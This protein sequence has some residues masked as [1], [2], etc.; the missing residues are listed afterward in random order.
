MSAGR[1]R[2]RARFERPQNSLRG[3]WA[4]LRVLT[5]LGQMWLIEGHMQPRGQ[6][7][8]PTFVESG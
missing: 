8:G 2:L 3:D 4:R 6:F 7:A 1:F 5:T